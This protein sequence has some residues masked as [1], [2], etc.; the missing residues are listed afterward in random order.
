MRRKRRRTVLKSKALYLFLRVLLVPFT[1]FLLVLPSCLRE[2]FVSLAALLFFFV[3]APDRRLSR[4][5]IRLSFGKDAPHMP[6]NR[7]VRN[8]FIKLI[9]SLMETFLAPSSKEKILRNVDAGEAFL[10]IK[11][12]LSQGKGVILITAH[13]GNPGLLC[14]VVATLCESYCLARYQRV[15]QPLMDRHRRER[16]VVTVL[17]K[18]TSYAEL[19]SILGQNKILLVTLDRALR[20][21]GIYVRFLGV[22][23]HTPYFAVDL[24]RIS[25]APIFVGFLIKS[26]K[27]YRLLLNGPFYVP[28]ESGEFESRVSF[29]QKISDII[30]DAIRSHPDEW[31]WGYRRW[32][33]DLG[34]DRYPEYT[35]KNYPNLWNPYLSFDRD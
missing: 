6:I 20:R 4:F 2:G 10:R 7:I 16:R 9:L 11:D 1:L 17:E 26:E 32:R 15:F 5:N 30:G 24:A 8:S 18:K 22:P 35:A 34:I 21:K 23:A 3:N 13:F 33:T 19:L 29:T 31:F 28:S 25:G 27:R 14:Y 12:A